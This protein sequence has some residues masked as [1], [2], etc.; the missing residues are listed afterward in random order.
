MSKSEA[1]KI[2]REITGILIQNFLN[3]GGIEDISEVKNDADRKR[4]FDAFEDL[5]DMVEKPNDA[6]GRYNG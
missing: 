3:I 1:R 6:R 2:A 5:R 4:M